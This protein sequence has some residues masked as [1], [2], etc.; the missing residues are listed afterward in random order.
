MGELLTNRQL[1]NHLRPTRTPPVGLWVV[2]DGERKLVLAEIDQDQLNVISARMG[3]R[4]EVRN[5]DLP[6]QCSGA[7]GGS[8]A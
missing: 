3:E 7:P 1:R 6:R 4:L 8:S 2:N 5:Y